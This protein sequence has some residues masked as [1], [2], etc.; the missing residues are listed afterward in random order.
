MKVGILL[1]LAVLLSGCSREAAE[2]KRLELQSAVA[3][4]RFEASPAQVVP[5]TISAGAAVVPHDGRTYE[6]LLAKADA[7]MYRDKGQR[8]SR[9]IRSSA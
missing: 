8:K 7:R 1:F 2:Q 6:T 3:R 4:V 9:Q 5:L